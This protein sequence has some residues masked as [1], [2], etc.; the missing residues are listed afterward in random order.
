MAFAK[1]KV[2]KGVRTITEAGNSEDVIPVGLILPYGS[3]VAPPGW[4][5]CD[6]TSTSGYTALAALVGATTPDLNGS[7]IVGENQAPNPGVGDGSSSPTG[8]AITGGGTLTTRT[9]NSAASTTNVS[10]QVIIS[11]SHGMKSHTHTIAHTHDYPHTH[12]TDH[13]HQYPHTHSVPSGGSPA[14][15]GDHA[16]TGFFGS[17]NQNSPGT[18][19]RAANTQT[20]LPNLGDPNGGHSHPSGAVPVGTTGSSSGSLSPLSSGAFTASATTDTGPSSSSPVT[21]TESFGGTPSPTATFSI[22]QPSLRV[23]FIIKY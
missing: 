12:D 8:G 14:T 1:F 16:H 7:I 11:H 21:A 9:L 5:M 15:I 22:E 3:S 17:A 6:G 19:G 20:S 2:K 13:Y 10:P 4:L 18:L 23:Y